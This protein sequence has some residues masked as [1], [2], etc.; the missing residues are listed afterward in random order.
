M[1]V[2]KPLVAA[3]ERRFAGCPWF[4][5][6]YTLPYRNLVARELQLAA[7]DTSDTVLSIG[8]GALPFSAVLA[9][10]LSGARVIAVDIDPVAAAQAEQLVHRLG[11][12]ARISVITADA[13]RD[14]LP[15]A[16]VALVALQAAPKDAIWRNLQRSL[17][18]PRGRAVFRL[19]RPALETEY[20]SFSAAADRH[21]RTAGEEAA[22]AGDGTLTDGDAAPAGVL[23]AGIRHRMPTFNRSVLCCIGNPRN[24]ARGRSVA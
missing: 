20:G 7:V 5:R 21:A 13:A 18:P 11:C 23:N 24:A 1:T 14:R 22:T 8:C 9:A 10:R 19:P 12:A 3:L 4:F 15:D 16:T 6:L 2:I 17:R